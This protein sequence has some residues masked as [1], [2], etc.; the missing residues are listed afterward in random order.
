M[1]HGLPASSESGHTVDP[2]PQGSLKRTE[3]SGEPCSQNTPKKH[4]CG[5]GHTVGLSNDPAEREQAITDAIIERELS[6][7]H[8]E[9]MY[10]DYSYGSS[11]S[12]VDYQ[13]GNTGLSFD[14]LSNIMIEPAN[15]Q[16]SGNPACFLSSRKSIA[17]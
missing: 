14:V 9:Q 4:M 8:F 11:N 13:I 15:I 3:S 10:H 16:Q 6:F 17:H 7:H 12:S 5:F 1:S 2:V